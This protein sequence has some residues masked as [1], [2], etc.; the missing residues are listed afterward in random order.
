[1]EVAAAHSVIKVGLTDI[2]EEKLAVDT[3]VTVFR[4]VN[5]QGAK[6]QIAYL[7]EQL[8]NQA[9]AVV[10]GIQYDFKNANKQLKLAI[11]AE[12]ISEVS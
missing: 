3:Q 2:F 10:D 12:L 5:E 1:M 6:D 4:V 9:R 11:I 8:R 7:N